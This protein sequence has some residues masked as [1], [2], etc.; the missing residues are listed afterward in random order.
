M[1]FVSE[2]KT[3]SVKFGAIRPE[4]FFGTKKNIIVKPIYSSLR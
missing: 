1:Q 4:E 2:K 3:I